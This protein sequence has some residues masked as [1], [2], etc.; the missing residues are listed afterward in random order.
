MCLCLP[1]FGSYS[2]LFP[3]NI[4][5]PFVKVEEACDLKLKIQGFILFNDLG[6]QG[7]RGKWAV[8][9]HKWT[10]KY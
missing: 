1:L 6:Q 10:G 7:K 9:L 8:T 2:Q 5:T 4:A 3:A